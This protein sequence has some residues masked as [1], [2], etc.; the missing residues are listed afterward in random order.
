MN[1][2]ESRLYGTSEVFYALLILERKNARFCR[3]RG[4]GTSMSSLLKAYSQA[5]VHR[6]ILLNGEFFP[7]N[8]PP[9]REQGVTEKMVTF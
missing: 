9:I 7:F 3:P 6:N 5:R 4:L 8:F 1:I 2:N